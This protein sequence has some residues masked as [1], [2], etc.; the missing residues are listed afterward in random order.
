VNA[1]ASEVT[2]VQ[3]PPVVTSRPR[4]CDSCRHKVRCARESIACHAFVLF[5]HH[6]SA[7]RM[8]FAPRQPTRAL[9]EQAMAPQPKARAPKVWRPPVDD[10]DEAD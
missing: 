4:P 10:D 1:E 7:A 6:A 8:A 3:K 9:W 2:E 5:M